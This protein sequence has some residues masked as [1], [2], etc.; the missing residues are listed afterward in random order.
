MK[1][2]LIISFLIVSFHGLAQN[3]L[4]A[5]KSKIK[6]LHIKTHGF[7]SNDTISHN[8]TLD[9][10][11]KREDMTN[12]LL[13]TGLLLTSFTIDTTKNVLTAYDAMNLNFDPDSSDLKIFS[14]VDMD[15]SI[16]KNWDK[17]IAKYQHNNHL[18]LVSNKDDRSKL[19]FQIYF[20]NKRAEGFDIKKS[21]DLTVSEFKEK[22]SSLKHYLHIIK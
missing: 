17:F 15:G 20:F 22:Y 6:I 10:L 14:L 21:Y 7:F 5:E 9:S 16:S 3:S 19:D 4:K 2:K 13:R 8:K 11:L 1:L 12:P 18:I